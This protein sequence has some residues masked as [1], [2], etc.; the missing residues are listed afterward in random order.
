M[1]KKVIRL[2]E[3]DVENLVRRIIKEDNGFEWTTNILPMDRLVQVLEERFPTNI[4]VHL[5]DKNVIK[6]YFDTPGLESPDGNEHGLIVALGEGFYRLGEFEEYHDYDEVS[7][8]MSMVNDDWY[9]FDETYDSVE[10][11]LEAIEREF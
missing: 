7:D 10:S 2:T 8:T 5:E 6:I 11:L 1:K 3:Q 4:D 9:W